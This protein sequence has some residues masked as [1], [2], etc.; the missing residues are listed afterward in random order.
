MKQRLSVIRSAAFRQ[1]FLAWTMAWYFWGGS[2][3]AFAG[4]EA[5]KDKKIAVVVFAQN[6][7]AEPV[8]KTAQARMEEVL[9][10]NEIAVLDEE[11]SKEL[12]DI[13]TLMDQPGVFVTPQLFAENSKKFGIEGLMAIYLSVDMAPGLADY[14]S[15]TAHADVRFVDNDTAQVQ[16]ISTPPMGSRGSPPSEGLTRNSA[17]INAVQRAVDGVCSLM[18]FQVADRTRARSVD[19]TLAGPE[20]W[21]GDGLVFP[22][23]ENDRTLWPMAQLE[24]Q[25]WRAETVSATARAPAGNLAAVAG[26]ITDTD[27]QRRPQRLFGSRVH[28]LDVAA[29]KSILVFDC[30]PVEKKSGQEEPRTKQILACAFIGGWRYLCAATGNHVFL[31]DTENG[32]E[33]AKLPVSAEAIGI[34]VGTDE[35]GSSVFLK[36]REGIWQYRMVRQP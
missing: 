36:T 33:V 6:E 27:F 23:I 2:L 1:S 14:F 13:F 5:L 21:A 9:A 16:A 25:R 29:R 31:W 17:A 15:A 35:R 8:V 32:R 3:N 19:L 26:Y 22:L 28:V 18:D 24:Q 4:I 20:A 30:S 11:K 34:T 10:D 12:T 7:L